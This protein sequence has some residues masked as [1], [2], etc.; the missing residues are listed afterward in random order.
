MK[1][2]RIGSI[3]LYVAAA[4]IVLS[5]S[6]VLDI[7]VNWRDNAAQAIDLFKRDKAEQR[8]SEHGGRSDPE[9]AETPSAPAPGIEKP[10]FWKRDLKLS[11][12]LKRGDKPPASTV[13][14]G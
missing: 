3:L 11:D 9:R 8:A 14:P 5:G 10:S 6:G 7:Q 12:L 2:A 4:V 1:P 13:E